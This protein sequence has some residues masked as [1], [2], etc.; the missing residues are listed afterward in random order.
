MS[1]TA[2]KT[3]VRVGLG[4]RAYDI[5]VGRDLLGESGRLTAAA[6]PPP[7]KLAIITN[8]KI[9]DLYGRTVQSAL[10]EA[11]FEVSFLVVPVG[12]RYKS[13]ASAKNLYGRLLEMGA[14]RTSA[15]VALGGGVVGDLAGFVAAT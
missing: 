1:L 8:T 12:E 9:G 2:P 3:K 7:R 11:G 5:M 14:D 6:L 10:A 13:L 15:I 4:R